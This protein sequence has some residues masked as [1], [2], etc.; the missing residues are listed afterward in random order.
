VGNELNVAIVGCGRI[1]F[2]RL[3]ALRE[4]DRLVIAADSVMAN[5]ERLAAESSSATATDDWH[6]AINHPAVEAVVVSTTNNWLA[7][8]SLAAVEAGK[9]VLV[10]KP[11][12]HS[13]SALQRLLSAA[14]RRKVT[15]WVGFN[16]RYHPAFQKARELFDSGILGSPMFVRGRYGHGGRIGYDREWRAAPE[17]SGGG[18]LLDQGTHLIDLSNWFLGEFK[19]AS[20][21]AHTYFWDMRVEDNAFLLLRTARNQVAWLHCS[22]TEWKNLFSFEIFGERGK[23]HIEGLGG[24]Y[25]LERLTHY[26]VLPQMGSPE[27]T[28][29]EFPGDDVSWKLEFQ[30]FAEAVQSG[31]PTTQ[32]LR[33]TARILDIVHTIYRESRRDSPEIYGSD[34]VL[35]RSGK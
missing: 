8:V 16:H 7:P 9:S 2:K 20:G 22:C 5:A 21:Y 19:F 35:A 3:H 6:S 29:W 13:R 26:R 25:G 31:I 15:V 27:T 24:S 32:S 4:T 11:A 30:Q 10:E 28:L 23:L 18:E 1:G 34:A 12:A 14:E 17:I 33:D